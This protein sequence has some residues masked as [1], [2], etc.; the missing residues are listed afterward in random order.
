MVL[1]LSWGERKRVKRLRFLLY[2]ATLGRRPKKRSNYTMPPISLSELGVLL[3]C[4]GGPNLWGID[5]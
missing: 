5:L 1:R 4:V 2:C 3:V